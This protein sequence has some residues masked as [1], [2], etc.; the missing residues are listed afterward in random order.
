MYKDNETYYTLFQVRGVYSYH[1]Y[2]PITNKRYS[3]S[4]GTRNLREANAVIA[5]RLATGTLHFP[6]GYSPRG[7]S[8]RPQVDKRT[9]GELTKDY[10]IEGKCPIEAD[11][12]K[13]GKKICRSTMYSNRIDKDSKIIP[14]WKD[15]IP[16]NIT[17]AMCDRFLLSLPEKYNIR[18][19]TANQIFYTF[20]KMLSQLKTEGYIDNNPADGIKPLASD[21]KTKEILTV[22]ELQKVLS[23]KWKNQIALLAVKTAAQTGMRIGEV[24]ALKGSQI[25]GLS[26]RID[27]SYSPLAGRKETKTYKEREVPITESLRKELEPYMRGDDDYIFSRKGEKPISVNAVNKNLQKAVSDAGINKH[28]SSHSLRHGMNTVLISHGVSSTIVK[29]TIGHANDRMTEHYLHLK[30][31]DLGAIRAVQEEMEE[32]K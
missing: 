1:C 29:A 32:V 23:V 17:P 9:F 3:R 14:F 20:R 8:P 27:A 2:D 21:F 11:M 10:F 31:D 18:R 22:A 19:G 4:C 24:S 6:K 7:N 30:A 5:K 12:K 16:R 25:V 15:E 28:I 13:R 26:I